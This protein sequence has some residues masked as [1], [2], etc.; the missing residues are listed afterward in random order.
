MGRLQ[1]LKFAKKAVVFGIRDFG[2]IEGVVGVRMVV[3][4]SAQVLRT[5]GGTVGGW[6]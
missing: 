5:C 2:R 4:V 1:R 3:Q 6:G